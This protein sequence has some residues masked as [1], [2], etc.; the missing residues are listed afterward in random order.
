ME[1]KHESLERVR[2]RVKAL[3]RTGC[4]PPD[5][6]FPWGESLLGVAE[7]QNSL[8]SKRSTE[9]VKLESLE[10]VW[11]R[12]EA[13]HRTGCAICGETLRG[14]AEFQ[15]SFFS[16]RSM[17]G[18][19]LESLERA[20]GRAKALHRTGWAISAEVRLGIAECQ[21]SFYSK[22]SMEG[23]ELV[24]LERDRAEALH[25]T[26]CA[27]CGEARLGI[28][29][30]QKGF[31]SNSSME[32]MELESLERVCDRA[33]A[34][35]RTGRSTPSNWF[36]W[37][38]ALLGIAECQNSLYS[39]RLFIDD[40]IQKLRFGLFL[41]RSNPHAN[42]CLGKAYVACGLASP[43]HKLACQHFLMASEF[44]NKAVSLDPGN[45]K[46][47]RSL[48]LPQEAARGPNGIFVNRDLEN[49]NDAIILLSFLGAFV[50][51]SA[52]IM[53]CS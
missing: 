53:L 47:K 33:E 35:H 14:V 51:L 15:D 19:K 26:G 30:F 2:Y 27:I 36:T 52:T 8:Y 38:E 49:G 22:S 9:G 7:C 5:N 24:S 1:N 4:A 46:Y 50:A 20:C 43:D 41:N 6:C 32:G 40:A 42:W 25:R 16:K 12:V 45:Q 29:E 23:M 28:A 37:G 39:K 17:E 44:F 10:G 13:L 31:D 34:L 3:H 11:D 21:Y 48:H 18:M